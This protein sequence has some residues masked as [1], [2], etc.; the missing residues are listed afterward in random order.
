MGILF[1]SL[2]SFSFWLYSFTRNFAN[3]LWWKWPSLYVVNSLQSN[4]VGF[5]NALLTVTHIKRSTCC[6]FHFSCKIIFITLHLFQKFVD[7]TFISYDRKILR[8]I[9]GEKMIFLVSINWISIGMFYC[10]WVANFGS[11]KCPQSRN[12]WIFE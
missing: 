12:F 9:S 7:V 8:H 6:D 3:R 2:R 10:N 4:K 1:T 5:E 11:R